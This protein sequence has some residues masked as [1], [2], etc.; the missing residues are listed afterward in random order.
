MIATRCVDPATDGGSRYPLD[1]EA[2][3]VSESP[4]QILWAFGFAGLGVLREIAYLLS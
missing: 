2:R 3:T 1:A 4:S